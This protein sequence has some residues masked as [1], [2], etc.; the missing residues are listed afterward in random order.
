MN[1]DRGKN[2]EKCQGA[3]HLNL[4]LNKPAVP[5]LIQADFTAEKIGKQLEGLVAGHQRQAQLDDYNKLAAM[6]G[7][8]GASARV[9]EAVV[10]F[11]K[12]LRK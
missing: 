2:C 7:G 4:I 9:A 11:V 5:E 10:G 3:N 1:R 12:K 6:V 8:P